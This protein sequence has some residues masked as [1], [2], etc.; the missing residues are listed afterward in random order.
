MVYIHFNLKKA[1]SFL[2][3]ETDYFDMLPQSWSEDGDGSV[4]HLSSSVTGVL[5]VVDLGQTQP[6]PIL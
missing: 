2:A 6:M 1:I 4:S 3:L 5:G